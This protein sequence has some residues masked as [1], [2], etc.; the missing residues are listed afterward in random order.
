MDDNFKDD[1]K[2]ANESIW[3]YFLHDDKGKQSKCNVNQ[4]SKVIKAAGGSTSAMHNYLKT[5]HN[6]NLLKKNIG[7][8]LSCSMETNSSTSNLT[9]KST[10]PS[11]FSIEN[12]LSAVLA[13]MT[14][15]DGLSFQVFCISSDLSLA[16]VARGFK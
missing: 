2:G 8:V 7:H 1:K 14:A 5:C 9:K 10:I 16:L 13:R 6:I 4:C 15:K 11:Y 12:C 3:F